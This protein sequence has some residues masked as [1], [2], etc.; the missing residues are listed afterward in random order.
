MF[1]FEQGNKYLAHLLH[2]FPEHYH[3]DQWATTG[4]RL[5]TMAGASF[6]KRHPGMVCHRNMSTESCALNVLAP[7]A[8]YPVHWTAINLPSL[9]EKSHY[10]S[11]LH[12][13]LLN[14]SYTLHIWNSQL[15]PAYGNREKNSNHDYIEEGS[16]VWQLMY[17]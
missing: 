11:E 15:W 16:L 10:S 5:W 17:G 14:E 13:R 7:E 3:P 12:H 9:V 4:P 2:A 1:G 8:L 6:E